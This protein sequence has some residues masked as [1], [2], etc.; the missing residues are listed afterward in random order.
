VAR[1]LAAILAADVVGYSRLMEKDEAGTLAALKAHRSEFI[2][3]LIAKHGGR[4]VKLMGDGALVEFPS[5]VDA[6]VSAIAVQRGMSKR[7]ADAPRESRIE[8]RIGINL[9]DIIIEDDDIYGDG[10][11]VAARVESLAEPGGVAL[12]GYAH[13]QVMGKVDVA[14]ADLGE[15]ELKNIARPIRVWHWPE[16]VPDTAGP[17]KDATTSLPLP[18]KPSIA[19]LP[20]ANMS[21]D[22]EQEYFCDGITEDIITEV[23]RFRELFI[24]A[25]NSSFAFKGQN[26]D[27]K[28]IGERL[29]VKFVVE[30]SV[31]KAGSRVRVTAQL[32]E[33]ASGNHVWAERYDRDLA[34]IFDVQDEV[35]RAIATTVAG[36]VRIT[37][38]GHLRRRPTD[39]LT[40]YDLYLRA[41]SFHASYGEPEKYLP[42]LQRAVELDPGFAAAHAFLAHA[43]VIRSFFTFDPA[44]RETALLHAQTALD[45]EPGDSRS[46]N[47]MGYVLM[48]LRGPD[49]AKFHLDQAV[50][51]NPNDA[52]CRAV[53]ALCLL[54]L[55]RP[56]QALAE[57]DVGLRLAPYGHDWFWDV[58]ATILMVVRRFEE[59]IEDYGRQNH[60]PFWTYADQAVCYAEL[61]LMDEAR[62]CMLACRNL[63]PS[64]TV[65]NICFRPFTDPTIN[66]WLRASLVRLGMPDR[67]AI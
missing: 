28:R 22:L 26:L 38:V 14:F 13:D 5:V 39:D 46:Q 43:L 1:R 2:D 18:D 31:R 44:M 54:Y 63:A 49:K 51:L 35:A 56:D 65:T 52:W 36:Q 32:I 42:L 19:I 9:G 15:H 10:V 23:S 57:I 25:R 40:A 17:A 11:N 8:F 6:V 53:R 67:P 7:N 62:A 21:G 4:I 27:I 34:D 47:A 66:E 37:T 30:G 64:A 33:I 59:A 45:L 3:P 58:R 20:F 60:R 24:V 50:A 16:S 12:S 61:G 48:Y 41:L 29:G 55:A